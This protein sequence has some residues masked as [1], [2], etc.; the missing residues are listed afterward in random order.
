MPGW[1]VIVAGDLFHDLIL[2][3][4]P[5]LPR[6]GEESFAS[7]LEREAGGG[8]AITACGLARLGASVAVAGVVGAA[9][10]GTLLDRLSA[11]GVD[12]ALIARKPERSTGVTVAVSALQDRA[13]FTYHG[14][15]EDLWSAIEAARPKL[16]RA[17]HVHFACAPDPAV[18]APVFDELKAAAVTISLDAG[19]HPDWLRDPRTWDLLRDTNFFFPNEREARHM[20]GRTSPEDML[21]DLHAR[22]IPNVVLKL[23][24]RG[25]I[26]RIGHHLYRAEGHPVDALDT[27]GAGDAFDAGFLFAWLR[28]DPAERCLRIANLCGAL[29]TRKPGG[30]A[31][32]PSF[33]E[34]EPYLEA[35]AQ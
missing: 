9:D 16:L 18:A 32:L 21:A 8:A 23:G 2:T 5:A 34:L 10:S 13:L 31:G 11:N 17:R 22:G 20:T 29:S 24:A 35:V 4:F 26:A 12:I 25:A 19:W 6:W 14:A 3:G 1:D 28:A 7:G 27:T 33:P 15:N 30:I